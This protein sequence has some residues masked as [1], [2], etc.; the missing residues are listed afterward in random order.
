MRFNLNDMW[1][2]FSYISITCVCRT[3]IISS[4]TH[5]F[6]LHL[7][8][9]VNLLCSVMCHSDQPESVVH[10]CVSV[11]HR[12]CEQTD[13]ARERTT[14]EI[15]RPATAP[16]HDPGGDLWL[17]TFHTTHT[18]MILEGSMTDS[19]PYHPHRHDPGGDLWLTALHTTHT[20]MILEGIYDWQPSIPPTQTWSWRGSMTDN[21]PYH[22]HR[23]DHG[24][25]LWLTALHT[26]HTDM[27]LEGIYDW[28]PSIPPTETW[29]WRGS[30]TDNLPYHP[31]RHD[32]GGDLWLTAHH[33]T[34][35]DMI[36]EGIYDWQ[37]SIPP[38]QTWSWR[39]SMTD[40]PT[41]HP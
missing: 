3:C 21:L 34:H 32:P 36:L 19:P 7:V 15:R 2:N 25:D 41:Y 31:H 27:I 38:K 23:H 8:D 29:S 24:G 37:P 1:T 17:T 5:H 4:H 18:D 6:Q 13:G 12:R 30:M 22:P 20:D 16:G 10:S 26:I 33:A 14:D 28:Q 40:S 39:G 9:S 35:K 11:S